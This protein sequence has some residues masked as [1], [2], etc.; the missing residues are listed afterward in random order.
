MTT[1][2]IVSACRTPQGRFLGRLSPFTAPRLGALAASA[3]LERA[4]IPADAI[5]QVIIG[6]VLAAG[7]GQNIARQI[8][9]G[10]GI[11]VSTTA[12]TVNMMCASGLRAISL[13]AQAIRAGEAETVLCGGVES[14]SNAP[15]LL[16]RPRKGEEPA[17][18]GAATDS[19]LRDGLVDAFSGRH[20]AECVEDLAASLGIGRERQDAFALRSQTLARAAA[21]S[22][23]QELVPV[24][25]LSADEHP[26]PETT[27]EGLASLKPSFR[28]D[29]TITAGNASGVNDGAAMV[30]LCAEG[31]AR[32][33]GWKPMAR[34]SGCAV[35]GC[36]PGWFATGPVAATRALCA[37]LGVSPAHFDAIE[38]NEAF[39]AQALACIDALGLDPAKVNPQ[40]GAI[41]LGHPIGASGA[42]LV[43]HLAHR[44]A[45]GGTVHGLAAL[46]A[47]G[48]MG[49]AASLEAWA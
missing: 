49:I 41:A 6:N 35:S 39:A 8:A 29:G 14:M 30:V 17:A 24:G 25:D 16:P 47:G 43:V 23:T 31:T 27:P 13:G 10:A 12:F 9:L 33:R 19:L 2:C 18:P 34:F 5:D 48:G 21:S 22:L 26:R 20:M 28:P 15:L 32:S 1:V 4:A 11:P 3:V 44:I 40:G 46:C 38:L 37:G 42:R 45:A 7:A 36:E